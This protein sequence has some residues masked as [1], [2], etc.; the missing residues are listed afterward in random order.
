M[1][2][3]IANRSRR[4]EKELY[5]KHTAIENRNRAIEISNQNSG[6]FHAA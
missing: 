1:T 4:V 2:A 3:E 5:R 6:D